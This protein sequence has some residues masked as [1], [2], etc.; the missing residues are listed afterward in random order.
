MNSEISTASPR[1]YRQTARAEASEQTG[2]RIVETFGACIRDRWF[3]EVTLEEV[4]ARAGVT[5]RTVL[6]RFGG[7][8]GLVAAYAAYL[9]PIGRDRR[10]VVPGD[11]EGAVD[12]LL[13][14]YEEIGDGTILHLAQE[15]RYEALKPLLETGR[16]EHRALITQV[17]APV[18]A[19]LPGRDRRRTMDALVI[20]MDIYAWKLLRRDIG[21]SVRETRAVMLA[22]VRAVLDRHETGEVPVE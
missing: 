6:R 13:T 9:V 2:R 12:G 14:F 22:M 16:R 18:L 8:E 10:G 7:K 17:F 19:S 11:I 20:A 15:S 21:R 3:D 4:A 1:R 5:V